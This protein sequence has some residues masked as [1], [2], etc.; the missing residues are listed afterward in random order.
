MEPDVTPVLVSVSP[1][2]GWQK[3]I[4]VLLIVVIGLLV[5]FAF[6]KYEP[7][8]DIVKSQQAF[9]DS[10]RVRDIRDS[11]REIE[12]DRVVEDANYHIYRGDSSDSAAKAV[13]M[14]SND[15]ILR[16]ANNSADAKEY[17]E[18]IRSRTEQEQLE[19]FMEDAQQK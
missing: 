15:L 7:P 14:R 18:K 1:G 12:I 8:I 19:T 11:L 3:I 4:I 16:L 5:Y 6:F 10:L 13:V 17:G 2:S 9:T